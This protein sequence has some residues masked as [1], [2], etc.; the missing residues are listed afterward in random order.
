MAWDR[1]K[2]VMRCRDCRALAPVLEI[3]ERGACSECGSIEWKAAYK[4]TEAEVD[5][6]KAKG[7]EFDEDQWSDD[8]NFTYEPSTDDT[9]RAQGS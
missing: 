9:E 1:T 8:P 3:C 7:Y 6:L 5:A 4:L 2:M